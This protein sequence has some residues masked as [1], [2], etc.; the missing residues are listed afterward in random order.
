[1]SVEVPVVQSSVKI[2]ATGTVLMML[3]LLSTLA[4]FDRIAFAPPIAQSSIS[5]VDVTGSYNKDLNSTIGSEHIARDGL[6]A[7]A[8]LMT[9][10]NSVSQKVPPRLQTK[11]GSPFSYCLCEITCL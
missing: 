1:M 10:P 4:V 9:Y 2:V 11:S 6:P 3:A 8:W 7:I 5:R